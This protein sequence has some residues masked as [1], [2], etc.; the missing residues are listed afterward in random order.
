MR[1]LVH[2]RIHAF[3]CC[4]CVPLFVHACVRVIV[5]VCVST[6]ACFR[7]YL[8]SNSAHIG[9]VFV[10]ILCLHRWLPTIRTFPRLSALS[11][12]TIVFSSVR[13][14]NRQSEIQHGLLML[15]NYNIRGPFQRRNVLCCMCVPLY[16]HACVCVS[17]YVCVYV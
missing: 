4:M 5:Y 1:A 14:I 2:A 7:S 15:F 9:T 17:F 8:V 6:C 11:S 3:V 10:N 13:T 16:S 12:M